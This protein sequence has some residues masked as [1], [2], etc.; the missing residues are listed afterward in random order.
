MA[1]KKSIM[2]FTHLFGF[3]ASAEEDEE[4]KGKKAKARRAEG[5]DREDD[6]EDDDRED[7]AEDDDREDDAED[8][9]RED[10]A[11]DDDDKPKGKGHAKRAEEDDED[12]EDDDGDDQKESA[13][14]RQARHA[15]RMRCARIFG[16]KHAAGN[17][18]LAASLAFNTGMSSAAAIS[19]M[20]STKVVIGTAVPA[21]TTASRARSL[22][23]RM[24]E[25]HKPKLNPDSGKPTGKSAL[26][27]KMTSLYN[28]ATGMK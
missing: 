9:D 18:A 2:G 20:A 12:A 17:P 3:G 22:D 26:V 15:E 11:E 7:D 28:S 6:A 23:E 16:S 14:I 10:D 1:K 25:E 27:S 4:K 19:V 8:D 13:S 5:D 21:S 24:R